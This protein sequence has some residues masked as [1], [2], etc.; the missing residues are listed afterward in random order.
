[1]WVLA[2]AA[3][4]VVLLVPTAAFLLWVWLHL[5]ATTPKPGKTAVAPGLSMNIWNV[6]DF[7]LCYDEMFK[8]K[9]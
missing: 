1:M 8:D 5:G 7:K 4:L 6:T 2:A 3:V 9:I